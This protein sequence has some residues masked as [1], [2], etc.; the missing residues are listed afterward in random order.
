MS[1]QT[2]IFVGAFVV[3][4]AIML[5][6]TLAHGHFRY[7]KGVSDTYVPAFKAGIYAGYE[8]GLNQGFKCGQEGGCEGSDKIYFESPL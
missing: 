1:R 8:S 2:K 6:A 3:Y 7:Q 4:S 5:A